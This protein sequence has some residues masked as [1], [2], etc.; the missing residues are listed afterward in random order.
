MTRSFRTELFSLRPKCSV[1]DIALCQEFIGYTSNTEVHDGF[2]IKLTHRSLLASSTNAVATVPCRVVYVC[3]VPL[4]ADWR[5]ILLFIFFRPCCIKIGGHFRPTP[6][7]SGSRPTRRRRPSVSTR[8]SSQSAS[9]RSTTW[10]SVTRTPRWSHSSS[11]HPERPRRARAATSTSFLI[12]PHSVINAPHTH[13]RAH[14]HTPCADMRRVACPALRPCLSGRLVLSIRWPMVCPIHVFRLLDLGF[15]PGTHSGRCTR[16]PSRS[17]ATRARTPVSSTRRSSARCRSPTR[18]L[19]VRRGADT[20]CPAATVTS[21]SR[22]ATPG[23][24]STR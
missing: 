17:R 23:S 12:I 16:C 9:S 21:T 15:V 2:D 18:A 24:R 11:S 10:L 3:S 1:V 6:S 22:S 14:T 7:A 20:G 5:I 8:A 4:R 13:T 19:T